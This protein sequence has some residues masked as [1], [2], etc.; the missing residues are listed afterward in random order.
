MF[1]QITTFSSM[2]KKEMKEAVEGLRRISN[3]LSGTAKDFADAV[4]AAFDE[5]ANDTDEHEVTDL[6]NRIEEISA[7][8]DKQDE[9]VANQ[10][11][12]AKQDMLRQVGSQPAD[13]K[14][15]VSVKVANE[16]AHA[17]LTAKSKKD[18]IEQIKAIAVKNDLSG[19][20]Y[21]KLVDYSLQIKQ[22]ESDEIFDALY[23]TNR[24]KWFYAEIDGTQAAEIAKQ[25]NGIAENVTEKTIQELAVEGKEI[26]TKYVYKRQRISNEDLD[27]AAEVGQEGALVNDV[28]AELRKSVKALAVKSILVGDTVN[29]NGSKVTVFETIGTKAASDVF[30][31]IVNPATA[32]TVTIADV[33][34]AAAAVKTGKKWLF[35]T[36]DLKLA[37][38]QHVFATG[39]TPMFYTDEE[40][41][42][43]LGVSRIFTKDYIGDVTGLHAVIFDPDEYWVKEKKTIDVAW[44]VYENNTYNYLYEINMGGGVRGLRSSAVLKEA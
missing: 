27:E 22:D 36:E 33:R 5:A 30:T 8:F 10:I 4:V 19:L 17:L 15:K 24:T 20:S 43:Q 25:W 23:K 42:A 31:T 29:G 13:V 1:N 28:R 39:G 2:K 37:L 40:L 7:R 6:K 9:E 32:N 26:D 44:P 41:A 35:I 12:K 16:V 34:R 11:A 18:A 3:T 14:N 38:A 21:E